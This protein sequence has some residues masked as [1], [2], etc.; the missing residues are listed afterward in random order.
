MGALVPVQGVDV[1]AVLDVPDR[2][3]SHPGGVFDGVFLPTCR[4]ADSSIQHTTASMSRATV[5]WLC[6][7]QIMSPRLMSISSARRTVTDIGAYASS[8]GPSASSTA[9]MVEVNPLAAP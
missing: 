4:V 1:E 9:A 8:I 3:S 6:G 7:R 2:A 5:G